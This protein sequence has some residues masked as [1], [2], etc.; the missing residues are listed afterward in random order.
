MIFYLN[1]LTALTVAIG[2]CYIAIDNMVILLSVDYLPFHFK[3]PDK[4]YIMLICRPCA[5]NFDFFHPRFKIIESNLQN[6]LN[7]Y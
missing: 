6:N 1:L 3:N 4:Y 7:E 5:I 2:L